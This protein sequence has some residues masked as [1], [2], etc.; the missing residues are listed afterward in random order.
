MRPSALSVVSL[1]P[2]RLSFGL[3]IGGLRIGHL[4][5]GHP[6]IT[7]NSPP[8]PVH[9]QDTVVLNPKG[10][11]YAP[12]RACG[13]LVARDLLAATRLATP[14]PRLELSC[15]FQND[16][17]PSILVQN[18]RCNLRSTHLQKIYQQLQRSF[19]TEHY[20][21]SSARSKLAARD[22][23]RRRRRKKGVCVCVCLFV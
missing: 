21:L 17:A 18:E 13:S 22:G 23:L 19:K 6:T 3:R 14:H 16:I 15:N 9:T 2:C 5:M 12:R 11:L 1:A 4:Q 8:P 20:S 7:P 10:G